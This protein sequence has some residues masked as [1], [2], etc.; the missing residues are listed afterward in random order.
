M[1]LFCV[2]ADGVPRF[3]DVG[4]AVE[5]CLVGFECGVD[6]SAFGGMYGLLRRI[7]VFARG[8]IL[9]EAVTVAPR[10]FVAALLRSFAYDERSVV[11]RVPC[12]KCLRIALGC[13]ECAKGWGGWA[14]PL[15]VGPAWGHTPRVM[16]R[17]T[18]FKLVVGRIWVELFRVLFFRKSMKTSNDLEL[19]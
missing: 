12:L 15:V 8:R 19:Y 6:L 2:R 7:A 4:A 11:H 13:A 14:L 5:F 3:L 17:L 18:A 9:A 10:V 16:L 1:E